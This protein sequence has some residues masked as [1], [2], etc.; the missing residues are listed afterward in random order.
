MIMTHNQFNFLQI[1]QQLANNVLK[2]SI[3][4]KMETANSVK[5]AII[6]LLTLLN[7]KVPQLLNARNAQKGGLLKN[8]SN[9]QTFKKYL[10]I[11]QNNAI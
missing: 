6:S 9:T 10:R 7:L 11:L 2:D 1:Q 4:I 5:M 8:N 3:K